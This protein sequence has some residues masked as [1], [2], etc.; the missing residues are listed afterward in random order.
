MRK[1]KISNIEYEGFLSFKDPNDEIL[2]IVSYEENG[3]AD[4]QNMRESDDDQNR[5]R[6]K[7]IKI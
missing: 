7:Y 4:Q 2:K 3:N 1:Y 5:T 6:E